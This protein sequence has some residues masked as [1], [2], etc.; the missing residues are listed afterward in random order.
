[1]EVRSEAQRVRGHHAAVLH[2]GGADG[3]QVL[4]ELLGFPG[5]QSLDVSQDPLVRLQEWQSDRDSQNQFQK[6][7]E[8]RLFGRTITLKGNGNDKEMLSSFHSP[9]I[10]K[11]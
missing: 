5:A 9:L 7:N 3:P 4:E 11:I 10:M 1:M 8:A 6:N 2:H